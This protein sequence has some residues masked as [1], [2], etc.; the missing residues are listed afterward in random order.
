MEELLPQD[1]P[2]MESLKTAVNRRLQGDT[3]WNAQ[4]LLAQLQ[5]EVHIKP[6]QMAQ[7]LQQAFATAGGIDLSAKEELYVTQVI[8]LLESI[9]GG[10]G[11]RTGT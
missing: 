8:S 2:M 5:A 11:A 7:E 6:E 10:Y 4:D 3:R 9:A 1:R